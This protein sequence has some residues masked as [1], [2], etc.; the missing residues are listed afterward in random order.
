ML[1]QAQGTAAHAA[2]GFWGVSRQ[3]KVENGSLQLEGSSTGSKWASGR[4]QEG[5][6]EG[7]KSSTM[8]IVLMIIL[9]PIV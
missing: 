8:L 1:V 2:R 9:L 4:A 7:K 6:E 5:L 3:K